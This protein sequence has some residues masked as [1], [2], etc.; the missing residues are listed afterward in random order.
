MA[1]L[2][3]VADDLKGDTEVEAL[4][5]LT[6]VYCPVCTLPPEFCQ[7]GPCFERCLPWLRENFPQYLTEEQL[8]TSMAAATL[9][10]GEV[11]ALLFALYSC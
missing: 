7:H 10:D 9:A 11:G 8:S 5:P 4:S 1:A 2:V 3:H 6:V